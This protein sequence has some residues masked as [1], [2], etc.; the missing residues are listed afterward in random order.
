VGSTDIG[1]LARLGGKKMRPGGGNPVANQLGVTQISWDTP[2]VILSDRRERRISV[3]AGLRP[4][5][6]LRVTN[7]INRIWSHPNQLCNQNKSEKL[8]WQD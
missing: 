5:A 1:C 7:P 2:D 8:K 3:H 4:F 6:S